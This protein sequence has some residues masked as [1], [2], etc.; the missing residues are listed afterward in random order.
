MARL[1]FT[2]ST[3]SKGFRPVQISTAGIAEDERVSNRIV[4]G[5]QNVL[6]A[7]IKQRETDLQAM[8]AN[9]EYTDKIN[10]INFETQQQNIK[11]QAARKLAKIE[12]Q[13]ARAA[14]TADSVV[15]IV[16][17]IAGFSST[18]IKQ[19]K[20]KEAELQKKQIE[21]E[22]TIPL[23]NIPID[24]ILT[25]GSTRNSIVLGGTL[26]FNGVTAEAK[27]EGLS[28]YQVSEAQVAVV[29]RGTIAEQNLVNRQAKNSIIPL[30]TSVLNDNETEYQDGA[31]N[32][33]T[34]QEAYNNPEKMSIVL[35]SAKNT[36]L[37]YFQKDS[38]YLGKTVEAF[39]KYISTAVLGASN[40]GIKYNKEVSVD[41]AKAVGSSGNTIDIMAAWNDIS[42]ING[43][44][45]GH[46]YIESLYANPSIP[47]E[48]IDNIELFGDGRKYGVDTKAGKATHP[49]RKLNGL[50]KRREAVLQ[51]QKDKTE[52]LE[53]TEEQK[54]LDNLPQIRQDISNNP[55]Q[56]EIQ[57][58]DYYNEK[59]LPLPPL[60][61]EQIRVSQKKLDDQ[62]R[63]NF[64]RLELQQ[65]LDIDYVNS[66]EDPTLRSEA[67]QAFKD[68]EQRIYGEHAEH[69]EKEFEGVARKL[70]DIDPASKSGGPLTYLVKSRLK[71]EFRKLLITTQEPL[72]ALE[73]LML[74]VD[75]GKAGDKDSV[76]YS[77]TRGK[78]RLYFPAIQTGDPNKQEE[79]LYLNQ[80]FK[81]LGSAG[82]VTSEPFLLGQTN[83]MDRIYNA[84]EK[85]D[86]NVEFTTGLKLLAQT[87]GL[88]LPEAFNESRKTN[89]AFTGQN[90]PLITPDLGFDTLSKQLPGVQKLI[91]SGNPIQFDRGLASTNKNYLQSKTRTSM[92][93]NPMQSLQDLVL[94]GEGGFTSA[95][96]GI[97]G[98]TPGGIPN[99]DSK[100]VGD[101]KNLYRQGYNALGGPQFIENTFL[102]AVNRLGLSDNTVMSG[103]VQL[104]LFN[105]LILGGVK[106]PRVS[107]YLNGTSNDLQSALEDMSL[108]FASVANPNT[109]ITSYPG[110]GG[111]AASIDSNKMAQVLQQIRNSLINTQ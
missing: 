4:K 25:Y 78:N 52:F 3:K 56:A 83:E 73:S 47:V 43:F 32:T 21:D 35:N 72:Q 91:M 12:E 34:A 90:K 55:E 64:E 101:W 84:I 63:S 28:P 68:Q 20:Q 81:E 46:T 29:G 97:A 110:V 36:L 37:N 59:G 108:E 16:E 41:R 33:F 80:K 13:N 54:L 30:V 2:P 39:D 79:V 10:Q 26:E 14:Q 48:N 17:S 8:Q 98:D 85:G 71:K 18:L 67:S 27:K 105:E 7:E 66:I 70:T 100:T 60:I 58:S 77:E 53:A 1:Q 86:T 62:A 50:K 76:F 61:K 22:R 65:L 6:D 103:D 15:N 99:L 104:K 23:E 94:S 93:G 89:N 5:M 19:Q 40:A 95:N 38:L 49:N 45:A 51:E 109:G 82:A 96:R 88:T 74:Q 69:I 75:K 44:D 111:N 107:A 106:R 92:G 57:Y 11:N 42:Q 31:G 24:Q 9:A 102:G 87:Y